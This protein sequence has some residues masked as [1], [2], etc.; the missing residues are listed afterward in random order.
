MGKLRRKKARDEKVDE[1]GA[2]EKDEPKEM[3]V[4]KGKKDGSSRDEKSDET[5]EQAQKRKLIERRKEFKEFECKLSEL[6]ISI[7]GNVSYTEHQLIHSLSCNGWD[8]LRARN[9]L[10]AMFGEARSI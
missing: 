7:P 5:M 8:V 10:T 9:S 3:E 6:R 2:K 1:K 4:K